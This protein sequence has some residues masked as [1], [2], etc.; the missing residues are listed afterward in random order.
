MNK[1]EIIAINYENHLVEIQK[2][3]KSR[4][5]HLDK[6]ERTLIN[7]N[8]AKTHGSASIKFITREQGKQIKI[9][10]WNIAGICAFP[11]KTNMSFLI[12]ERPNI[13]ALQETRCPTHEA[14]I[15]EYEHYFLEDETKGQNGVATYCKQRPI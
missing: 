8:A 15:P 1:S 5:V 4:T 10:S 3:N 2:A 9:C 14:R 12:A 6:L 7:N 11:R 13:I